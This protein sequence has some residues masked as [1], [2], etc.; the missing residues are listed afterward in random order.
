MCVCVCGQVQETQTDRQ[1]IETSP[2]LQKLT[3]FEEA[4]GVLFTHVRLLARA[5][6]LRTVGFNHLTL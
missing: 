4:I 2:V 3:D 1:L 5:L 6:T